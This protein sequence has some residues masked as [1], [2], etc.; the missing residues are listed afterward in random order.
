MYYSKTAALDRHV[1]E[2]HKIITKI[3]PKAPQTNASTENKCK[4]SKREL[5]NRIE[6]LV[7]LAYT[8]RRKT[9]NEP[10]VPAT[11]QEWAHLYMNGMCVKKYYTC[12]GRQVYVPKKIE[13]SNRR[14]CSSGGG[15]YDKYLTDCGNGKGKG[16]GGGSVGKSVSGGAGNGGGFGTDTTGLSEVARLLR[17]LNNFNFNENFDLIFDNA[18]KKDLKTFE[19]IKSNKIFMIDDKVNIT[20][21]NLVFIIIIKGLLIEKKKKLISNIKELT[22]N[23]EGYYTIQRQEADIG[24][25][26]LELEK[27]NKLLTEA[28]QYF[29]EL[30]NQQIFIPAN[31][32]SSKYKN[33]K[34]MVEKVIKI[35]EIETNENESVIL[36]N[37][38]KDKQ[39]KQPETIQ[40]YQQNMYIG[41][42]LN[43]FINFPEFPKLPELP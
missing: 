36:L 37:Q 6:R 26:T 5:N 28:V 25:N 7:L 10:F 24:K 43:F 40:M 33:E 31:I 39:Q 2:L 20:Y 3:E 29:E 23:K 11:E 12:Q 4:M 41:L 19:N 1:C 8:L 32:Y 38:L 30:K 35:S 9:S 42:V 13:D 27:I 34:K 17:N 16:G 21:D 18:F 22:E 14:G 15:K